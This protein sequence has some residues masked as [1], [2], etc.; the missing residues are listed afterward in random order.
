MAKIDEARVLYSTLCKTL[1]DMQWSYQKEEQNDHFAVY[2]SA[3]GKDLTMKLAIRIDIDRQVMY[4]KSPM[5]FDV[6]ENQRDKLA[7]AMAR[8]NWSMLNGSFET[9]HSDGFVAFKLV[10]PYMQS[11]LSV[12]V[13]R[14]MI[15][16]SCNMIDKFNDKLKSVV[17]DRMTIEELQNFIDNN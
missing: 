2:T 1:D 9:D 7:L 5:P 15:L 4:L 12:E 6:P 16:L 17:E 14:Y 8:V 11:M 13:C 10:V 3:V